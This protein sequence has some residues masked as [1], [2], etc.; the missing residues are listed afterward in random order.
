MSQKKVEKNTVMKGLRRQTVFLKKM[1]TL[2]ILEALK[3]VKPQKKKFHF[4][5][6]KTTGCLR[7]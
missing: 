7:I 6:E 4:L 2:S 1:Q 5:A 3:M